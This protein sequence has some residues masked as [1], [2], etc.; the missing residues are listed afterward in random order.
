MQQ[1]RGPV[2]VIGARQWLQRLRD[3]VIDSLMKTKELQRVSRVRR[4]APGEARA[5]RE[6]SRLSL[7]DL[8]AVIGVNASS[9]YRWELGQS[10]PRPNVALKWAH[11][12]ETLDEHR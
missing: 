6:R 3:S 2:S 10:A 12:L 7:R 8:A 5:I 9:L 11:V 4:L 1:L